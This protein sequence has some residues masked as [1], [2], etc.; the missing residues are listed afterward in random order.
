MGWENGFLR[1]GGKAK[2]IFCCPR[3]VWAGLC[4]VW[5]TCNGP[6]TRAPCRL[7]I[8]LFPRSLAPEVPG[9]V[10]SNDCPG[11]VSSRCSAAPPPW[12]LSLAAAPSRAVRTAS[13]AAASSPSRQSLPLRGWCLPHPPPESL[14]RRFPGGEGWGDLA[15]DGTVLATPTRASPQPQVLCVRTISYVLE[16]C[17]PG[18]GRSGAARQCPP[19]L[20]DHAGVGNAFSPGSPLF[21]SAPLCYTVQNRI[22]TSARSS[23]YMSGTG[24]ARE[25]VGVGKGSRTLLSFPL[26]L[27]PSAQRLLLLFQHGSLDQALLESF[28]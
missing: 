26:P 20:H 5:E 19:T 10:C 27:R 1:D 16:L 18:S 3:G 11:A 15:R 25:L 7:V 22:L 2:R 9:F 23:Q 12:A 24:G 17:L 14:E 4:G 8:S 28:S 21:F 13:V 6:G